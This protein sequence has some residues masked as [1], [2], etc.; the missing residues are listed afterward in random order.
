MKNLLIALAFVGAATTAVAQDTPT[1][2]YSVATNTFAKNW[3]IQGGVNMSAFYSSQEY[4]LKK[5]PTE[6]F[7]SNIG[8]SVGVGKWF[9]PGLGL[10]T[11]IQ[12]I[13]GQ[14]VNP[15]GSNKYDYW[16]LQEQATLNLSNVFCGYNPNRVWNMTVFGGAGVVRNCSADIYSL[17][18]SIGLNSSWKVSNRVNL[19]LEGGLVV[20]DFETDGNGMVATSS[21]YCHGIWDKKDK[22]LYA[23]VGIT[24]NLGKTGWEKTPD[25]DAINALH[26][27]Q[28]DALNAQLNDANAEKDRLA[29]LLKEAQNRPMPEAKVVKELAAVPAS[30]FFNIGKSKIASKKDL[31][32]VQEIANYAKDNNC[33][34][35]VTGYADSATGSPAFNQKLSEKRANTVADQLVNMGVSRDNI[36]TVAEGGVNT[37][38]P[39]SYNRRAT[40]KIA[41]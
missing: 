8:F 14:Q 29:K 31:V 20:A 36:T 24:V 16:N 40:V 25:V 39:I 32:N 34:I 27:S 13:T 15:N 10:R 4:G 23:E 3:Y 2:K 18:T 9:T 5:T 7:R 19:Y 30:V 6:S 12:G 17:A 37:L 28:L 22:Q 38:S 1:Q 41:E 33:K 35:V 11:K 26:Q 21:N